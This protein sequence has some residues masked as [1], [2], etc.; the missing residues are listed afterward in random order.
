MIAACCMC[1]A[2]V[3]FL[4]GTP[5]YTRKPPGGDSLRGL[6]YYLWQSAKSSRKGALAF[7]GWIVLVLFILLSI[8]Q[9]CA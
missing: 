7:S 5:R 9:A 8:V 3:V 2:Y 4:L 1:I 6:C